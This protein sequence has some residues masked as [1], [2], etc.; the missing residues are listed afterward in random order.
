MAK[1]VAQHTTSQIKLHNAGSGLSGSFRITAALTPQRRLRS[2][3]VV[4]N[5]PRLLV[6]VRVHRRGQDRK[7]TITFHRLRS[8]WVV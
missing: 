2:K 1:T 5:E 6:N 4:W 3:W 7:A 8:K